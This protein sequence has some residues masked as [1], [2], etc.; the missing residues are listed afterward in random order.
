MMS[1]IS[2]WFNISLEARDDAVFTYVDNDEIVCWR[3]HPEL[4]DSIRNPLVEAVGRLPLSWLLPP[5]HGETFDTYQEGQERVLGHSLAAGFQSV[6]GQGSTTVRKNIWCIHHGDKTQNN[7][8][9]SERVERDPATRDVISTHQR[10]D[11]GRMGK[12]YR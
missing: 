4:P 9:L 6:G 10:D 3:P 11:T 2:P 12:S 5:R 1:L 7:R 8:K